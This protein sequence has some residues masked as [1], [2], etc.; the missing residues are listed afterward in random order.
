MTNVRFETAKAA[1]VAAQAKSKPTKM[2]CK[3]DFL[4]IV[5]LHYGHATAVKIIAPA[6]SIESNLHIAPSGDFR[7]IP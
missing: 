1:F 3:I 6:L 4:V 7:I 5:F 2:F